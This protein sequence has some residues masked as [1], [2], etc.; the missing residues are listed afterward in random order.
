VNLPASVV[1]IAIG[2]DKKGRMVIVIGEI[3]V[4]RFPDYENIG[5]APFNFAFHLKKLGWPVRLITR[6]G[7][8][9]DGRKIRR[10]LEASGFDPEDVQVDPSHATGKV[11]VSLSGEGVPSFDICQDVAYDHIDL[12]SLET[13]GGR[14]FDMIYFGSLIQR[15]RGGFQQMRQFLKQNGAD[16]TCFCDI[17]LRAPHILVEAVET[18]MA[19]ADILKLNDEELTA[20][21][22]LFKGPSREEDMVQWLMNAYPISTIVLTRGARGSTLIT[23]ERSIASAPAPTVE[24]MDTVGAGDAY[25]AMIAAGILKRLP[26]KKALGLATEFSAR[27]CGIA[28]AIP[29]SDVFYTRFRHDLERTANAP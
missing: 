13:G 27:I 6:I 18:A 11:K 26:M 20:V 1:M 7:D 4:D 28:G 25:A 16:A 22:R 21:S 29:D 14:A 2:S 23:R 8:D 12:S 24:I 10:L 15:T 9:A 3:L 17:N 5:G 19:H